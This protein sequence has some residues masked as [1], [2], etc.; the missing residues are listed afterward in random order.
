[1]PR[2]ISNKRTKHKR[3]QALILFK[4]T[5]RRH[6]HALFTVLSYSALDGGGNM[7]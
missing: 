5:T 6:S 1:M 7:L 4:F 2:I 3:Q